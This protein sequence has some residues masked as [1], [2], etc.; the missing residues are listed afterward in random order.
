MPAAASTGGS[1]EWTGVLFVDRPGDYEFE[2]ASDD[3]AWLFIADALV[4]DNGGDHARLAATGRVMLAQG[5]QP[6]RIRYY[7]RGGDMALDVYW[8]G[9]G[10]GRHLL[11]AH[12]LA[13]GPAL[14]PADRLPPV[15]AAHSAERPHRKNRDS[16]NTD[17]Q[18]RNHEPVQFGLLTGE[19]T[20]R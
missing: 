4:V 13:P 16:C 10:L 1:A 18:P 6:I 7:Q 9:P 14:P 19:S 20:L 11:R 17:Q 2:V 5:A 3:G 15:K 8:S 12:E